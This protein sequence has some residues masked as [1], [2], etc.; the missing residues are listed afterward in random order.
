MAGNV[1]LTGV[2]RGLGLVIAERLLASGYTVIGASRRNSEALSD[3]SSRYPGQLVFKPCDLS[4]ISGLDPIVSH[5]LVPLSIPLVGFVN[6]AAIAYDDIVTNL[7]AGRISEMFCVNVFAPMLITKRLIRNMLYHRTRGSIVHISSIS[8]HTGYKGLAM[9]AASKGALEA[10]SKNV[11]REWG[12]RGIR[13]NCI[14]AGF[15]DTEMSATLSADQRSRIYA[16]TALK[17]PTSLESVS[18]T[19][20]FLLGDHSSSIT[21][22]GLY[23]DSGTI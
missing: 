14:I 4:N 16:R 6:N 17:E 5:D 7:D 2:S 11:A 12:V 20:K 18:Q 1:L 10:F 23:V 21:G 19:V 9:Y 8:V 3:L 15:M 22:Q 13:S